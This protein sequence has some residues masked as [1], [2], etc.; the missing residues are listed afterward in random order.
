M[1][2]EGTTY[3]LAD[4]RGRRLV[5]VHAG[6]RVFCREERVLTVWVVIIVRTQLGG[7]MAR[8]AYEKRSHIEELTACNLWVTL[9]IPF[10]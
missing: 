4:E 9:S 10:S 3:G 5:V 7:I 8:S 1:V 2:I 6:R